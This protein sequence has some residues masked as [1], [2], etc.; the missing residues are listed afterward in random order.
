VASVV[1]ISVRMGDLAATADPATVLVSIGLGSCIGLALLDTGAR[2]AGLAH[3]ML[4]G[5]GTAARRRPATFADTGVLALVDAL[6]KLGARR[7]TAAIVGGAHMF[8]V[9]GAGGMDVGARNERAVRAALAA[10]D[11]PIVAAQTGGGNG[12]TIRVYPAD[13]R[14]TARVAGASETVLVG[15][16]E[17]SA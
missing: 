8:G 9:D 13:M 1:E 14:V 7:L 5:P 15:T 2:V 10:L 6:A 17:V 11:V 3:I 12:R 4:P 16:M